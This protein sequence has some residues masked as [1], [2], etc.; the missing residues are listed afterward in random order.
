MAEAAEPEPEAVKLAPG[1]RREFDQFYTQLKRRQTTS[2]Y[3]NAKQTIELLRKIVGSKAWKV[4]SELLLQPS[5][6]SERP[7][8]PSAH[9]QQVLPVWVSAQSML[10][11]YP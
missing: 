10:L 3:A 6:A 9:P 5:M 8:G 4:T 2:A 11:A 7:V 1:L